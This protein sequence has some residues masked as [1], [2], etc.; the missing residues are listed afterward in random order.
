MK[1]TKPR[2]IICSVLLVLLLAFIWGNS[3]L[4]GNASGQVSGWVA[5]VIGTIF[6]F[7][8]AETD[9]GH[10]VLRKLGHFSE[11][12]AL[13]LCLAWLCGMVISTKPLSLILPVIGGITAAVIDETIQIFTPDRYSSIV[14]VGIDACGVLTG[15]GVMYLLYAIAK[16]VCK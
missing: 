1:R 16:K 11:F 8:S 2:I 3:C 5:E 14:D 12:A 7:L 9:F 15:F 13:G 4:P 10:F 6:P